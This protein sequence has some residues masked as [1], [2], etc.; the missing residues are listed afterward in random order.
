MGDSVK[1]SAKP[2]QER[3]TGATFKVGIGYT[4]KGRTQWKK[5]QS[6]ESAA[7]FCSK[8]FNRTKIVLTIV[9]DK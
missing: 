5:F 9:G 1:R 8:V 2:N 6:M 4:P 7:A 3:K